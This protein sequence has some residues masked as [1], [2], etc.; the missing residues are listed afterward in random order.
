MLL[1]SAKASTDNG[2]KG[3][4]GDA[5]EKVRAIYFLLLFRFF[6]VGFFFFFFLEMHTLQFSRAFF[7]FFWVMAR[8]YIFVLQKSSGKEIEDSDSSF[9][10]P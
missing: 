2:K 8:N 4:R 9:L 1:G 3:K 5:G 6:E 10:F 7:F